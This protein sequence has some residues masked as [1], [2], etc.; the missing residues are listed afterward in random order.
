[1]NGLYNQTERRGEQQITQLTHC[2]GVPSWPAAH[3]GKRPPQ[4]RVSKRCTKG[5]KL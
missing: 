1:L 2:D 4:R 5:R 3:C